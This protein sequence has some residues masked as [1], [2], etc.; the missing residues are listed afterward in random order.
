M[1]STALI[2]AGVS[3]PAIAEA[4]EHR[5]ADFTWHQYADVC[6]SGRRAVADASTG[7]I[8]AIIK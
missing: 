8:G 3:D 7:L 1:L 6:D 4:L 5:S 2:N